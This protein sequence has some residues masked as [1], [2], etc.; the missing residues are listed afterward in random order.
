MS[1]ASLGSDCQYVLRYVHSRPMSRATICTTVCLQFSGLLFDFINPF[2]VNPLQLAYT[3]HFRAL[4]PTA[5][6]LWLLNNNAYSIN[7]RN[8]TECAWE[9]VALECRFDCKLCNG[10]SLIDESL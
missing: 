2:A 4:P 3:V 5:I 7:G 6:S 10:E 8:D 1:R 9:P